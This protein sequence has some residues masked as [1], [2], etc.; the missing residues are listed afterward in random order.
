MVYISAGSGCSG[1]LR[2]SLKCSCNLDF[3]RFVFIRR[4]PLY[5]YM[6][7][8][9]C[10]IF[11]KSFGNVINFLLLAVVSASVEI[12][13]Q[14]FLIFLHTLFSH[15]CPYCCIAVLLFIWLSLI[16]F[17]LSYFSMISF[18]DKFPLRSKITAK[19][20]FENKTSRN[21]CSVLGK[22][23]NYLYFPITSHILL[24]WQLT[25]IVAKLSL[26]LTKLLTK[27]CFDRTKPSLSILILFF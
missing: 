6:P 2:I 23:F 21:P 25:F 10:F 16:L 9:Y 1:L 15:L 5:F 4:I 14:L 22:Q 24:I 12:F 19:T 20:L 7:N 11:A 18:V 3:T 27:F 17:H 8:F 13:E 26:V